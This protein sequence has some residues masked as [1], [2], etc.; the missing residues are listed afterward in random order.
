MKIQDVFICTVFLYLFLIIT[1]T[2]Q[3]I[4]ATGDL[5]KGNEYDIEFGKY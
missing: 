2:Q 4:I 3:E 5:I 1:K